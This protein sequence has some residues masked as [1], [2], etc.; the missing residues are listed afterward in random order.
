MRWEMALRFSGLLNV[1]VASWP[2]NSSVSVS[3]IFARL[4]TLERVGGIP[5]I[6]SDS[7]LSPCMSRRPRSE[8]SPAVCRPLGRRSTSRMILIHQRGMCILCANFVG[9]GEQGRQ[10]GGI[11]P[12]IGPGF[13]QR[14][15]DVFGRDVADEIVSGKGAAAEPGQSAV[16]AAAAG[17]VG[18]EDFCF[19]VF[20]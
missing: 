8:C 13:F 18:R 16:E 3:N 1:S 2:V 14:G 19:G 12:R 20:G 4:L 5:R 11:D 7:W 17:L 15:Q 6:H 10:P 9:H